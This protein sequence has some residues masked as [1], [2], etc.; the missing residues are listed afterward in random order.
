MQ[1]ISHAEVRLTPLRT[2]LQPP[3]EPLCDPSLWPTR[4]A[5]LFRP[6]LTDLGSLTPAD[7]TADCAP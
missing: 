2:P 5:L 4:P 3:C 7:P 6:C 1:A